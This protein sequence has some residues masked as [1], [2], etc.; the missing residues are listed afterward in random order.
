MVRSSTRLC[1]GVVK[2]RTPG[3]FMAVGSQVYDRMSQHRSSIPYGRKPSRLF[4]HMFDAHGPVAVDFAGPQRWQS[5]L[6]ITAV[7][8]RANWL[9]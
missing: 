5:Y 6:A 7:A 1:V 4:S 2:T 3:G 9:Q 8:V